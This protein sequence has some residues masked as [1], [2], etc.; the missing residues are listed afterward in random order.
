MLCLLVGKIALVTGATRGIGWAAANL[1]A[2]HGA[3]VILTGRSQEDVDRACARIFE[4]NPDAQLYPDILDVTD[5]ISVKSCF[6]RVFKEHSRLDILVSNA[7]ILSDSLLGM[8]TDDQIYRTYE[9]NVF[10]VI[11]CAQYA[12]R[13]MA[14]NGVGGSIVNLSSII[15]VQGDVGQVVYGSSKAAVVGMTLSLAK[16]LAPMNIRVNAVAPGFIDTDMARSVSSEHFEERVKSI[17][18][19]RIGTADEVAQTILFLAS[20]MSS[21][22]TGQIIG[23]DGGMQI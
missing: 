6:Q 12:S 20:S 17:R 14:R 15:G 10:G 4:S 9:T 13:L 8:A 5:A 3:R 23:V 11:R 18:M 2:A 19:G 1:L 22:V 7:G 21:Y 16:E